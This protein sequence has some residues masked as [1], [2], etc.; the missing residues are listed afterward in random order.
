MTLVFYLL[1]RFFPIFLGTL[2]FFG[3]ALLLVDLLIN[4]WLYILEEVSIRTIFQISILY[5]PKALSFSMPLAILFST[6]YTLSSLYANNEL[7]AIFS[8]GISLFKFTLPI[9]MFSFIASIALFFFED[10]IVVPS[11]KQKMDIQSAALNEPTSY[12]NNRIVVLSDGGLIIYR[13]DF[14]NDVQ[15]R[16]TNVDI[17]IRNEDKSLQKIIRADSALWNG[18]SWDLSNAFTYTYDGNE[19]VFSRGSDF[20]STE[21]P[22]TFRNIVVSVEEVGVKE[23]R[24]YIDKLK[25]TGLP[26][27]EESAQYHEKFSFPFVMFI[28][29]FL[30]IG[31]S[32]KSK[33][34][35]LLV[36][37][38]LC[39]SAAVLFYVTQM[40][41]MLMA[42][43][44]YLSPFAGAW[45]PVFVF[46]GISIV[47]LR[48]ART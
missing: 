48:F 6:A 1:R 15:K 28:T 34:N 30:S 33:K 46:I 22:E 24:E 10:K 7:T 29:V 17:Y 8:S 2:A 26:H 32:G 16:L 3:F 36:S 40:V 4:L 45:L 41:T 21:S 25:R 9:L 37:L 42:K 43:F 14:Y 31:L 18:E 35:V 12:D 39:V 11:L 44:G 47:L 13:I 38:A 19:L 23:A 5:I 27:G 20:I